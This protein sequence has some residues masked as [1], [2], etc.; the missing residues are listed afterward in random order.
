MTSIIKRELR[1]HSKASE[2]YIDVEFCYPNA[3]NYA[4]SIP[5]KYR[6]TGTDIPDDGIDTYLA[7]VHQDVHPMK[8]TK[9]EEEQ[10]SFWKTKP[11]ALV[12]KPFFDA[13]VKNYEWCCVSCA[14]PKNSNPARRI[15]DLKEFG[16]TL[17]TVNRYCSTCKKPTTHYMLVP[18]ARGGIMGYE[19]W[20]LA[21][22]TR[23][24]KLL[25]SF[26]AYEA[27]KAPK[28][29]LLPDHKFPEIR[30]DKNTK[31]DSLESLS[32]DDITRDFQLLSNQRNQQKREVCRNCY[33]T[34]ERGTIYGITFFYNGGILWD[35]K[36]PQNGKDAEHGC[37]GCGWY[38]IKAWR[39]ALLERLKT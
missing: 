22:R 8:R 36:L 34:G 28:E 38:D 15:Q 12:T 17:A 13:L 33:Q 27:K 39:N 16:Y 7:K 21:M 14:L 3:Q 5:L 2:R 30:W 26:D 31:R 25:G 32:D 19:T 9:W 23:I 20:T 24:I 37:K 29:E 4:T 1:S 6:R 18:L 35:A 11:N 10:K